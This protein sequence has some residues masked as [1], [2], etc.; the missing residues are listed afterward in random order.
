MTDLQAAVIAAIRA[1]LVVDTWPSGRPVT[2]RDRRRLL[3]TLR[4]VEEVVR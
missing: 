3:T 4:R 2:R 1:V